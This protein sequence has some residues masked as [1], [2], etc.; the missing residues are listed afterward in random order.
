MWRAQVLLPAWCPE[1]AGIEIKPKLPEAFQ[2]AMA[3]HRAG[4]LVEAER[5]YRQI[6][7]VDPQHVDSLHFLGVLAGQVGRNDLAIDLIGRALALK[8]DYADAHY[9]LGNILAMENRLDQAAA[10]L[11]QALARKPD[12]AEAHYGLG[13]VL[14]AQGKSTKALACLERALSLK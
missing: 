2:R 10:H 5:L 11:E 3:C 12:S 4:N 6:C 9:N 14:L 8:P 7:A 1:M 13:S